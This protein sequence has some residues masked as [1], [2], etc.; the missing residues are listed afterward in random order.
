MVC[1]YF[2]KIRSYW[3]AVNWLSSAI[4]MFNLILN[5]TMWA[6]MLVCSF[7]TDNEKVTKGLH[8]YC[9]IM[10]S[11]LELLEKGKIL[12]REGNFDDALSYFE[13]ALVL[14]PKNYQLWNQKGAAL[15][16]LGRYD[17]ALECF[18]RALE[19]DP[20]DRTAS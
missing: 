6:L 4:S 15:R 16:S 19:L 13:Q 9:M 7:Q 3:V 12:L 18:N 10:T 1:P 17:D 14:E 2:R 5:H 8:V 11:V 20:A